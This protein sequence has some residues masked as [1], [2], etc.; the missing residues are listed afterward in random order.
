MDKEVCDANEPI[1]KN[2]SILIKTSTSGI[3]FLE[4]YQ[5]YSEIYRNYQKTLRSTTAYY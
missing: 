3:L 4:K 5:P 1:F 2:L